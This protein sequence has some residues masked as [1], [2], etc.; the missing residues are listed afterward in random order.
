[1]NLKKSMLT[2]VSK[3]LKKMGYSLIPTYA[4]INKEET[5]NYQKIKSLYPNAIK[6]IFEVLEKELNKQDWSDDN[7]CHFLAQCAHESAGF[8]IITENLNYSVEGLKKIFPKYFLYVKNPLEYA[9]RPEKIANV[10]YANRMGNGDEKSGDGWKYRG[11]G[12]IQITGKYNYDLC[13]KA[14]GRDDPDYL[15]TPEGAVISAIW[16][17]KKNF[18]DKEYNITTITK[19]VNGGVNGLNDRKEQYKKI[20]A[21][22]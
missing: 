10:V 8:R 1:M 21:V 20:K 13:L 18:L 5:M 4:I 12:I 15:A 14:I 3:W 16:F 7:K 17:W 11:R 2:L 6:G 9:R 19:R 22:M